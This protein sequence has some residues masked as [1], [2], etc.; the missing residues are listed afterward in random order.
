MGRAR[1]ISQFKPDTDGLIETASIKDANVTTAKIAD[2]SVTNVKIADAAVTYAKM[3]NITAGRV[4]GRDTSG[5]GAVQELPIAMDSSGNV[6]IGVT[7]NEKLHV[8]GNIKLNGVSDKIMMVRGIDSTYSLSIQSLSGGNELQIRNDSGSTGNMVAVGNG[9]LRFQ[10]ENIERAQIDSSGNLLVGTTDSIPATN[11]DSDGIALRA[12]GGAQFSRASAATARF[13]RGSD[14]ETVSFS[15]SGT[16]VGTI[17]VTTTATAYNTSSDYRLKEDWQPMTGALAKVAAL[18]P[19]T[20]KWK[21]DGSD[22]QGFIAHELAEV[23]PDAVTGEKDA[24]D[25][26]G[27]P[28]YQGIDTSFLVA[29]LVAAI[30]ELKSEFDAYKAT[31][32]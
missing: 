10:T 29:T 12:D 21:A 16:I 13:N 17:S 32:P 25:A 15:R 11:N 18:K 6:G 24:V 8:A 3:Q 28:V 9:V 23:V 22:G 1:N 2:G 19:C 30:Q 31:H 5:N 7:P 26:D 20:Y 27:N 14:G 4:L